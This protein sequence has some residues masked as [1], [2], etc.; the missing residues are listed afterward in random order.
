MLVPSSSASRSRVPTPRSPPDLAGGALVHVRLASVADLHVEID[1]LPLSWLS[2]K[3]KARFDTFKAPTRRRQFLAGRFLARQCLAAVSGAAWQDH[4]LSAPED[5]APLW[6]RSP[7]QASFPLRH[8][9]LSHSA[10]W[11]ACAVACDPVGVDIE[12]ITRQRDTDALGELILGADER[13]DMIPLLPEARRERFFARWAL[14]EAW[15][16]HSAASAAAS[17]QAIQCFPCDP[18][19]AQGMIMSGPSF[20]LAVVTARPLDEVSLQGPAPHELTRQF[21]RLALS[22]RA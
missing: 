20:T 14:K 13:A 19:E 7:A 9:S 10:D 3:E 18:A 21:W 16:K 2:P 15:I 5:A 8:F 11:L 1:G 6:I 17:M 12:D 4:E 22:E